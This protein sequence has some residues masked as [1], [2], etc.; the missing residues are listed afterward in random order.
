MN[1]R[2]VSFWAMVLVV[3]A[4]VTG[5]GV[6]AIRLRQRGFGTRSQPSV[7]EAFLAK[8]SRNWAIP[9]RARSLRNPMPANDEMLAHG[10]NHWADHCATCHANNGSG[11][12]EIGKNLYPKAP[13]MRLPETQSLSDGELYYINVP[14]DNPM[15]P[16]KVELGRYLFYDQRLSLNQTQSCASC[17]KQKLAFTDG[18]PRGVGSTGELHPRG[19]MSLANVAYSPALTWANVMLTAPYMHDGSVK[20]IDDVI[21]HY[22][23]GGRTIKSGPLAGVGAENPNRSDF[24]QGFELTAEERKDLHAFLESLTDKSFLTDPALSNPW[25][26]VSHPSGQGVEK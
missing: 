13:D 6:Y 26:S 18:R 24:V 25:I 19:A 21:D 16:E 8:K 2:R 23:A 4:I 9:E 12:T 3:V 11:E 14:A 10:R 5:V 1:A 15:T 20:T 17:H 22:G 7:V